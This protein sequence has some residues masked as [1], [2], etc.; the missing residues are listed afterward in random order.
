MGPRNVRSSFVLIALTLGCASAPPDARPIVNLSA[1]ARTPDP[2]CTGEWIAAMTVRVRY[3]QLR[4]ASFDVRPCLVHG[5]AQETTCL[6]TT[7]TN[8]YGWAVLSIP[9]DM[10]CVHRA[11]IVA[12][13][14]AP[15]GYTLPSNYIGYGTAYQTLRLT[16]T[17]GV[18]DVQD[19]VRVYEL[20][21][22]S[23]RE[24]LSN[25][26]LPHTIDFRANVAVAVIPD[27]FT[28]RND[29]ERLSLTQTTPSYVVVDRR[30]PTITFGLGPDREL[31]TPGT[32]SFPVTDAEGTVYD[33]S[34][35]AG[36]D[37]YEGSTRLEVGTMHPYASAVVTDHRVTVPLP[38]IGWIGLYRRGP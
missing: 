3:R 24:V 4:D 15:I 31:T 29:Y 21:R 10:R 19:A 6:G 22:A 27:A 18:L 17:G 32:L 9:E 38:R 2:L 30:I 33:A 8:R 26:T 14:S 36:T 37:T 20:D 12:S 13:T 25:P 1:E 7:R 35:L 5:P 23:S 11:V 34:F 28:D 16:P